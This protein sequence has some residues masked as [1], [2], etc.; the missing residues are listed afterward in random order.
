MKQP[1]LSTDHLVHQES[2]EP[3]REQMY[4]G[5]EVGGTVVECR[6]GTR[7]QCR[8]EGQDEEGRCQT[9]A[10]PLVSVMQ[11]RKEVKQ[12]VVRRQGW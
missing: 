3:A 12:E 5:G 6:N 7:H 8:R 2:R 11:A 9:A 10:L 4:S 1:G